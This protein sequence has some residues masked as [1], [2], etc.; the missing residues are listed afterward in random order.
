MFKKFYAKEGNKC[1]LS[2]FPKEGYDPIFINTDN[3]KEIELTNSGNVYLNWMT[4]FG[5]KEI[6]STIEEIDI[7]GWTTANRLAFF[8]NSEYTSDILPSDSKTKKE[9]KVIHLTSLEVKGWVDRNGNPISQTA[10]TA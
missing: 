7:K 4:E 8:I 2:L 5:K 10:Q 9:K 3:I 6:C 1:A